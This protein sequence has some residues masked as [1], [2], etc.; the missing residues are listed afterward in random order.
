MLRCQGFWRNKPASPGWLSSLPALSPP[1]PAT[2]APDSSSL[3]LPHSKAR[4]W[5]G[6]P[7]PLHIA[8]EDLRTVTLQASLRATA[9][10]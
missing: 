2:C 1:G 8:L 9:V 5:A 4:V 6:T 10:L 7:R 3:C